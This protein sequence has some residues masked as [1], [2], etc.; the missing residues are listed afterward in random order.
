MLKKP[1]LAGNKYPDVDATIWADHDE[2]IHGRLED[3]VDDWW[4]QE[5]F[6]WDCCDQNTAF[7]GCELTTH[8][9]EERDI[10]RGRQ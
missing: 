9:A 7:E 5:G 8:V 10:K 1:D 6:N 3:F 2:R 4:Y